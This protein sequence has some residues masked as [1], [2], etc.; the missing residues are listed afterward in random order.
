MTK[1]HEK[2]INDYMNNPFSLG[3]K[4]KRAKKTIEALKSLRESNPMNIL[5]P[6][7]VLDSR[8]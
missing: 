3:E 8:G 5:K 7:N 6:D 2:L 1:E 4:S